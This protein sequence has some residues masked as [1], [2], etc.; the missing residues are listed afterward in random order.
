ML[1]LIDKLS[2]L[3][4]LWWS[5]LKKKIKDNP[6]R[7]HVV[8]SKLYEQCITRQEVVL[9]IEVNLDAYRLAKNELSKSWIDDIQYQWG[10]KQDT[11]GSQGYGEIT[12]GSS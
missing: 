7:W 3:I 10:Y 1:K 5:L 9:P 2:L 11:K 8:F 12:Q 4:R 6:R